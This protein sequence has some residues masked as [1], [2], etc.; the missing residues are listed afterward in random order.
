LPALALFL[1][2]P[3]A[4]AQDVRSLE[5]HTSSVRCVAFSPDGKMLVS[6]GYDTTA[7]LWEVSTGKPLRILPHVNWVQCAT[8]SPDGKLLATCNYDRSIRLYDPNTGTL[9]RTFSNHLS[10]VFAASFSPDSKHVASGAAE[11]VLRVWDAGTLRQTQ[12]IDADTQFNVYA[13]AFSPDGKTVASAG[14]DRIVRLWDAS[15]GREIQ[16]FTGHIDVVVS[17]A[18]TPDGRGL[19][20]ASHDRSIRLWELS[21]GKERLNFS[22]HTSLVRSVAVSPDGRTVASGA[23]DNTVRLWDALTGR[24]L[25]R[26]DGHRGTVWAVAFSPDGKLLASGA[27]DR[28]VRLWKVTEWTERPAPKGEKLAA[29]EVAARWNDLG[30]EDGPKAFKAVAE[31]TQSADSALVYFK[32]HL[33]PV[34]ELDGEAHKNVTKLIA[35]LEAE[36]FA[37]RKKAM[38]ALSALGT[39]AAPQ[40]RQALAKAG[41]VDLRLRLFVVLRAMDS[42][43][44]SPEQLRTLRALEVLER[45]RTAEA[46]E[47]LGALA[48]GVPDAYLTQQAKASLARVNRRMAK[49]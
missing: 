48:K 20:S 24:E 3:A 17:L 35:D 18:F 2:A 49:P 45:I 33:K 43:G 9:L 21:T 36:D 39:P 8:F 29:R 1:L 47:L 26:L 13:V 25:K 42:T 5:G 37:T 19:F 40:L 30:D 28:S 10:Q 4:R 14:Q 27:E 6:G 44:A 23:Y 12:T 32:E 15:S 7:R 46:K 41:D 34:R 16:R 31:L 38:D 11:R 22:G